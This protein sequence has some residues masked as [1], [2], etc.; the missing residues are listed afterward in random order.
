MR[1]IP[2]IET[3]DDVAGAWV[4]LMAPPP[5]E[6]RE[7]AKRRARRSANRAKRREHRHA[8]GQPQRRARWRKA[9]PITH[10][11]LLALLEYREAEAR[12]VWGVDRR[13]R[14]KAGETA[15]FK[16]VGKGGRVGWAVSVRGKVYTMRALVHF[17]RHGTW[18]PKYRPPSTG[19]RGVYRSKLHAARPWAARLYVDGVAHSLGLHETEALALAAVAAARV[20]LLGDPPTPQTA[21]APA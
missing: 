8:K 3:A 5:H 16:T 17:Y 15:G 20:S 11:E 14:G 6:A 18:P 12:F 7:K 21:S 9:A 4:E 13:G 10:A 2:L 19:G 1:T